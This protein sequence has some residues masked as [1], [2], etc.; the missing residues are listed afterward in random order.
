MDLFPGEVIADACR[1]DQPGPDLHQQWQA[2][3]LGHQQRRRLGDHGV[4]ALQPLI[5]AGTV[6]Q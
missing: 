6:W 5:Q 1:I 3:A 4:G 2:L